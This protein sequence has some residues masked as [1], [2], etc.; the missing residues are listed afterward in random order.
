MVG[1]YRRGALIAA[2]ACGGLEKPAFVRIS[3]K[4]NISTVNSLGFAA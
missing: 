3:P 4:L 2:L 1:S